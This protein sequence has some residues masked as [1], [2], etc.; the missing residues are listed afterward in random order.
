MRVIFMGS[1]TK[2]I[3]KAF[4]FGFLL[5]IAYNLLLLSADLVYPAGGAANDAAKNYMIGNLIVVMPLL[6]VSLL[7]SM[8][9]KPDSWK[10]ALISALIMAAFPVVYL[11]A[12]AF[13]NRDGGIILFDWSAFMVFAAAA[14]GPL[15][16]FLIRKGRH[17]DS[18]AQSE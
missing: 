7:F 4:L 3:L 5:L 10:R 11:V 13:A 8:A 2:I 12:I 16:Y 1:G 9:I 6:V 17:K 15:L 14:L 18:A